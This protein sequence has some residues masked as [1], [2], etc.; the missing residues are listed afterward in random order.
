LNDWF[1]IK[2]LSP[3]KYFWGIEVAR[4]PK[5]LFLCQQRYAM[6][7][8]DECVYLGARILIPSW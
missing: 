8:A 5:G 4:G 6:E 2:D 1:R 3:L 7:I